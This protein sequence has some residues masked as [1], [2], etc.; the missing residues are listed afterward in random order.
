M[1]SSFVEILHRLV[2]VIHVVAGSLTLIAGVVNLLNKKGGRQHIRWGRFY[3]WCMFTIFVTSLISL[4]F[5][6]NSPLV[7]LINVFAFYQVFSGRR[8]VLRKRLD[9]TRHVAKLDWGVAAGTSMFG[10]GALLWSISPLW[11]GREMNSLPLTM[12][13]A[14]FS[15]FT[16]YLAGNDIRYFQNPSNDRRWWWYHHMNYMIGSFTS[17]VTA[18]I[19]TNLHRLPFIPPEIGWIFWL[20]PGVIGLAV[21]FVWIR[22]YRR[23]FSRQSGKTAQPVAKP[24]PIELPRSLSAT[25][26]ALLLIVVVAVVSILATRPPAPAPAAAPADTFSAVRASQYAQDINQTPHPMGSAA[27]AQVRD[28][29]LAQLRDLGLEPEQQTATGVQIG[30]NGAGSVTNIMARIPGQSSSQAVLLMSHYDS[31][32]TTP[33]ANNDGANLGGILET[34]RALKAAPPL[35]NDV[36]IFISDG[37][38]FGSFGSQIFID[39]HPWAQDVGVV[40]NFDTRGTGGASLLYETSDSNGWMIR[41]YARAA[42]RPFSNSLA[43]EVYRRLPFDTDFTVFKRANYSGFNFAYIDGY[44]YYHS[45]LDTVPRLNQASLQSHGEQMLAL[46]RHFGNLDLS[47]TKANNAVYFDILQRFLVHYSSDLIWPLTLVLLLAFAGICFWG[48]RRGQMTWKGILSGLG[49]FAISLLTGAALVTLVWQIISLLH[50]DYAFLLLDTYNNLVYRFAFIALSLAVSAFVYNRLFVRQQLLN[51]MAGV[52]ALLLVLLLATSILAPGATYLW[53]WPLFF[54]LLSLVYLLW[55]RQDKPAQSGVRDAVLLTL[56]SLPAI[57]ILIPTA[58]L[59]SIALGVRYSGGMAFFVLV[60]AG[61]LL[62]QMRWVAGLNRRLLPAGSL[63]AAGILLIAGSVTSGFN[64]QQP[65][66]D[67]L[68]YALD[69]DTNQAVWSTQAPRADGWTIAYLSEGSNAPLENIFPGFSTYQPLQKAAPAADI[70]GPEITV[71]ENQVTNG[72]R[73]LRLRIVSPRGAPVLRITLATGGGELTAASVNGEPITDLDSRY[74]NADWWR[75]IY[76]AAPASGIELSVQLP[77][78]P[79]MVVQVTDQSYSW[80]D[81]PGMAQPVRPPEYMTMPTPFVLGDVTLV[82]RQI[83]VP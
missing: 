65:Q 52:G 44:P 35:Q 54:L 37:E 20:L 42:P 58:W 15:C 5:F 64:A 43:Y 24:I 53:A 22:Y 1:E 18:V 34:V 78:V 48:V 70:P 66:P 55:V 4:V 71:L 83:T 62:P 13:V 80:P 26:I 69:A 50:R 10:I 56:L 73:D 46:T 67:N 40:F 25:L 31:P 81:L 2:I 8:V 36:I 17:A 19:V 21:T 57:L 63:L 39:K 38:E 12:L 72:V 30:G 16:I 76:H 74:I 51:L 49:G 33:G 77:A 59:I 79:N 3:F 47:Q 45:P 68:F 9:L 11:G 28:Y 6:V 23:L 41:E 61:L 27:H 60:L 14:W 75:L 29:L 7:F 82:A 32:P